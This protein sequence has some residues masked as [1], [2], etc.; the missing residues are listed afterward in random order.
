MAFVQRQVS[1][2][3]L[4]GVLSGRESA[5]GKDFCSSSWIEAGRFFTCF[6]DR[7]VDMNDMTY[8]S[9]TTLPL[10]RSTV[11]SLK[12]LYCSGKAVLTS[13]FA[14]MQTDVNS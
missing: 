9:P 7:R 12:L 2:T 4:S 14:S 10:L 13:V 8:G 3:K 11:K 1:D 5:V 6:A